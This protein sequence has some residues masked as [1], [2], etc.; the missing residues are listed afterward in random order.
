MKMQRSRF[1]GASAVSSSG[2]SRPLKLALIGFGAI[3]QELARVLQGDSTIQITQ[4]VT[5]DDLVQETAAIAGP[6]APGAAVGSTIVGDGAVR[7]DLVAECA[8]HAAIAEHIVPALETGLPCIITSVGALH[9]AGTVARLEE[10]AR[11]GHTRVQ[12][13]SGAIGCIDALSAAKV[14]GLESVAYVGRKPPGS[15]AQTTAAQRFDLEHL[16]IPQIIFE[17]SAREAALLYPQNANVAATVALAGL[18]LDDTTVTLI[19]DPGIQRNIH[20]VSAHGA[21]GR[22]ALELENFPLPGNPKT[23]ALAA[24]SLVCAI[25]NA[26]APIFF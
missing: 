6:L 25:R 7:P 19:A 12:L 10:A 11:A 23:S 9:H 3:G 22:F 17:G 2:S 20:R 26:W 14:A 4:I 15:W 5:R 18:G 8:G 1:S 16:T 21:F 24:C 13:I